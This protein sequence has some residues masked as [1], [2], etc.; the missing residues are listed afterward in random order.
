[1]RYRI[2]LPVVAKALLLICASHQRYFLRLKLPLL[3]S[4]PF[5]S[6]MFRV[7][8]RLPVSGTF[9]VPMDK[10]EIRA[11]PVAQGQ[12]FELPWQ[13]LQVAPK[14]GV[15]AGNIKLLGGWYTL[16]VRAVSDGKIVG[17]DV[18]ASVGVGEMFHHR[19]TVK[20]AGIKR[21]TYSRNR[22]DG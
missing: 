17:R 16:E 12:G 15:F 2:I 5:I 13:D 10:V 7:R 21:K 3:L 11:V 22:R 1:M 8:G 20:C 9:T 14:G 18:L 6:K 4:R 19:G